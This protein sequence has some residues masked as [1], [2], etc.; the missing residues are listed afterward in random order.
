MQWIKELALSP[1]W[2]RS[3]LWCGCCSLA[4]EQK[5]KRKEKITLRSL[6]KNWINFNYLDP[7]PELIIK[8]HV[9]ET[10]LRYFLK[11][12]RNKMHI[13]LCR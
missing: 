8:I 7:T 12:E 11:F 3:L 9:R 13:K 5:R 2:L 1:Q 4:W 6:A 10:L